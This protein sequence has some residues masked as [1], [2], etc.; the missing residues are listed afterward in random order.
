MV[1]PAVA[2]AIISSAAALGGSALSTFGRS[3]GGGY[4]G[5]DPLT[6]S[7]LNYQHQKEFAQN[8]IQWRV[9]DAK[10]AGL[11]P[12]AALGASP[13]GFSPSFSGAIPS[14]SDWDFSAMGDAIGKMGQNIGR[15][16]EAQATE[17][18]RADAADYTNKARALDLENKQLQND[19]LRQNI[20]DRATAA[21]SAL[22]H[23]PGQPP[24][25][26]Q[27]IPTG[28]DGRTL[29]GQGDAHTTKLFEVKPPEVMASHPQTPY[30]EAGSH[31]EVE[32]L[33]TGDGGYAPVRSTA[34][35]QALEDD[36][37][38]SIRYNVRNGLGSFTSNQSYAPP[39]EYL[40]GAG[41]DKDWHWIYDIVRGTW[42]PE[43]YSSS[44]A[45]KVARIFGFR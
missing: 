33:R 30:A 35:Q 11:H 44:N 2:A 10:A 1:A 4:S 3:S 6:M 43:R 13:L 5:P 16:I 45:S 28:R 32:W 20:V 19:T 39:R 24:A 22:A 15:A 27:V 7:M 31:P 21:V 29:P 26:Q 36:T 23:Q 14:S 41:R 34:A 40:P 25:M 18:E 8:A 9:A 37:I 38:G 12:L 17:K 42:H